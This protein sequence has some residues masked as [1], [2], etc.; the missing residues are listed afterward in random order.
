M[1]TDPTLPPGDTTLDNATWK[2][3]VAK[4]QQPVAARGAWQ[5]AN[6]LLP[7]AA[8]WLLA[9]L[10]LKVS[11]WLALPLAVLMG[12]FLVRMFIIS[13]DCG[14]SSFFKSRRANDF[15]GMVTGIITWVP[16]YHWRWEHAVHHATSGDLDRR[17]MGDIWTLTVQEYL[18]SSRWQR[19]AYRLARNPFILFVI[20]PL[21][22]FLI[23]QRLPK[24]VAGARERN[25]VYWTNLGIMTV[26]AGLIWLFGFKAYVLLQLIAVAVAGSAGVWLFYVQHQF[27]GVYWERAG[28]WDYATAALHGSSFYKL[29]K[30]LQWFSGNIGFHHIHHLSSRIPNYNLERAHQSE[31]LFQSIKPITL[32]PSLKC[33]QLRLWDEHR[34]RLVGYGALKFVRSWRAFD[35]RHGVRRKISLANASIQV[36]M[37]KREQRVCLRLEGAISPAEA[38]GLS[39]RIRE[40]LA[41][42]KDR[43]VLDLNKLNWD[44]IEDLKPL[45]EKLAAY[46]SRI[47]LVLP[48]LAAAHPEVILLASLFQHYKG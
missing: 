5:L 44:K 18:E 9:F 37:Q 36:E 11:I 29:P 26:A 39:H 46:R 1:T 8:L 22:I 7:Y 25:S 43:L 38:E 48:R 15:W 45:R 12:G 42:S 47:R 27:E 20:A 24:A 14:H 33:M 16:Y 4:Y 6:T 17:G 2:K 30:I 41:R 40:A 31:A 32:L 3:I 35:L 21:Y 23:K 19:F 13:H 34:Q 28:E 10:A